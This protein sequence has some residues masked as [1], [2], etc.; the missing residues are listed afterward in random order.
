M[1]TGTLRRE[2]GDLGH[3]D[4]RRGTWGHQ[5]GDAGT[6]G[7]GMRYVKYR[8]M[9]DTRTLMIIAKVRGKCY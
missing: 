5:V 2:Y 1:G 6:G 7:T 8:D 9:G 3:G 4:A